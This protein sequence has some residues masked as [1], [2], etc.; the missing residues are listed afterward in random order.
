[1]ARKI[2]METTLADPTATSTKCLKILENVGITISP[3]TVNNIRKREGY[4]TIELTN[5]LFNRLKRK[6][7]KYCH[8]VSDVN[9]DKRLAF[10][11]KMLDRGEQFCDHVFT[12]ETTVQRKTM[13]M[14]KSLYFVVD[15]NT[16]TS[17]ASVDDYFGPIRSRAKHPGKLHIWGGI[18]IRGPTPIMIFDGTE[19]M[20][21]IM[22]SD[23]VRRCF[24]P[25]HKEKYQGKKNR[26]HF[27]MSLN[28]L[29]EC[30]F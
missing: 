2:V 23:I 8:L 30:Q 9:K 5:R 21:S 18:S 28:L 20:D 12:D 22:Y 11:T 13:L 27:T 29:Q 1:M 24:L 17:W 7:T 16:N 14:L 4:P 25:F 10:C 15:C 6:T 19:R 3:Q 26:V